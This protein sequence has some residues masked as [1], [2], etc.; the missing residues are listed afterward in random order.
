[1]WKP[2]CPCRPK[3][4]KHVS[5]VIIQCLINIA[6]RIVMVFVI[7]NNTLVMNTIF[8]SIQM[9]TV[10][11]RTKTSI[12]FTMKATLIIIITVVMDVSIVSVRMGTVK[13]ASRERH[14]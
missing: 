12:T 1:M 5:Y 7:R 14:H 8:V 10:K 2:E 11:V 6:I 4:P 13:V 9:A 3:R